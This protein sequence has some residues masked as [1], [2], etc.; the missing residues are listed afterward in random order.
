MSTFLDTDK[1]AAML[2]ITRERFEQRYV[3]GNHIRVLRFPSGFGSTAVKNV[4]LRRDVERWIGKPMPTVPR[5]Q[6]KAEPGGRDLK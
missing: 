1:A 2:G 6:K 5:K 4:F 3:Y